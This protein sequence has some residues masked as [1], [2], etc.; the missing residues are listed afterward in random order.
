MLI[1]AISDKN[2][3]QEQRLEEISKEIS[4]Q[5]LRMY[6]QANAGHIACSLSCIDL[7]SNL[8]HAHKTEQDDF[9]LSKGHAAAGLYATLHS[10]GEISDDDLS[11]FYIDGTRLPAHPAPNSFKSIQFATGSLGHGLPI[12]NG[13]AKSKKLI[14]DPS[15]VFVLM[16]DGETNE[17][18]NWEA[19]HFA[20][21]HQLDNLIVLIDKNKIQGFGRC[22]E[23]LGDSA[24]I[25]KWDT[26]G[27]D[28]REIGGHK[29]DQISK[30]ISELK[31]LKNGKPKLIIANT[32]K[33][34][35]V[36]YMQ[37]TI[38][39][40]YWPMN[41]EQYSQAINDIKNG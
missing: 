19:A 32:I 25:D 23:V 6:K 40:H 12:G 31:E 34:K 2:L 24:S 37:D 39:W 5:T 28:C 7:L 9:I 30:A 1:F 20:A 15:Y 11:T 21:Q 4:L 38:D 8:F 27:F 26:L 29:H 3:M 41:E 22:E 36:H 18:S 35:G 17:G 33:G 16:S 14:N 10:I 13:I